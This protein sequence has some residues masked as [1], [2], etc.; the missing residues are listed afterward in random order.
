MSY[1]LTV[2]YSYFLCDE[3]SQ[4]FDDVPCLLIMCHAY[5]LCDDVWCAFDDV[6]TSF[7]Y[8]SCSFLDVLCVLF[9]SACVMC[10]V[11]WWSVMF[12]DEVSY[13]TYVLCVLFITS[14]ICL[15][16]NVQHHTYVLCV[17]FISAF[18]H[19]WCSLMKCH[20]HFFMSYVYCSLMKCVMFID[21]VSCSFL[22]V[23]CVLFIPA[24]VLFIDEVSRSMN[25]RHDFINDFINEHETW[26][27]QWTWDMQCHVHCF[28]CDI[29]RKCVV[30]VVLYGVAT[31]SKID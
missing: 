18:L 15:M 31:V 21:E 20:V 27:D 16:C 4:S 6:P 12:I 24:C 26:L 9:M 13:H 8:V 10:D 2:F 29:E 7:R 19:V 14:H 25:M 22:Y 17:M 11:D 3:V 23:L 28:V 1:L 30:S 5:F